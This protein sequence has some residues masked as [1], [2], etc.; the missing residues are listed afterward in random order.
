MVLAGNAVMTLAYGPLGESATSYAAM[1]AP[2]AGL[3][4]LWRLGHIA[5]GLRG[6]SKELALTRAVALAGQGGLLIG[7]CIAPSGY[8]I[9]AVSPLAMMV[10]AI[11]APCLV[12]GLAGLAREAIT[13]ATMTAFRAVGRRRAIRLMFS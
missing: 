4:A 11:I 8:L 5:G 3:A 6:L 7:L 10:S 12:P 13:S 9:A 1:L 2:M